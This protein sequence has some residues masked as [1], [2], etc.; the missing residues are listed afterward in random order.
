M[1]LRHHHSQ[2]QPDSED[3]FQLFRHAAR[4]F[5]IHEGH[6]GTRIFCLSS[7]STTGRTAG[8]WEIVGTET[9]AQTV[10]PN[11]IVMFIE[12]VQVNAVSKIVPNLLRAPPIQVVSVVGPRAGPYL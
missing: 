9:V 7:S 10:D 5:L 11:V 3:P 4:S 6:E 2:S 1:G 8:L 12:Q